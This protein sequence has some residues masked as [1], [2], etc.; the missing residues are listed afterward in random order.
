VFVSSIFSIVNAQEMRR[1]TAD[2]LNALMTLCAD[3]QLLQVPAVVSK[4]I[5]DGRITVDM[6]KQIGTND[7]DVIV[8]T[9]IGAAPEWLD[10]GVDKMRADI[11]TVLLHRDPSW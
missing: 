2:K 3:Q 6:V 1:E 5:W 9:I 11:R 10:Y 4:I 7:E 8:S